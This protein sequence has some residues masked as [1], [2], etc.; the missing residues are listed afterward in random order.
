MIDSP[1]Q[2]SDSSAPMN[3]FPATLPALLCE[4]I[5]RPSV[6][7][8]GDSGGTLANETLM[9][10][11]VAGLLRGLGGEVTVTQVQPGRPNVVARFPC[12]DPDA[13][14]VALVPH[15]DTVG[16]RGMTVEPFTPQLR[17]GRIYGRG[18]SDTKGPMAA[19]LWA[20][21]CWVK[22]DAARSSG[23]SW[24]FAATMGEEEMSTGASALCAAGFRAD[25]AIA[26]EPTDL[27]IIRASKGVLRLWLEASGVACHAST[28]EK[29]V[30]AIYKALPFLQA[31]ERELAP[32][33]A[34]R[35]HPDLGPVSINVGI[36]SGG[37]EW[38]IVPDACRIGLDMRTH[39][40]FANDAV[41]EAVRA[42][43]VAVTPTAGLADGRGEGGLELRVHRNGPPYVLPAD[44][45]WVRALERHARGVGV[46]P[47]FSDA[48]VFNAHGTPAVAFGPGK[49]AQA[50][51]KDEFISVDDL[52]EGAAVLGRF[53]AEVSAGQS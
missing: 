27:Q 40:D 37:G 48:N 18:A 44:N 51:T 50:H 28:P 24:V 41:L 43:A 6:S 15:L 16:V 13:P 10:D 1:A 45:R 52:E 31:C 34:A 32:G 12:A 5:A 11:Y 29:G 49:M 23:V 17:E 3:D 26:L 33:F 53:I 19:A 25:F 4:L 21:A 2:M 42:A 38:N 36:L 35:V 46:A 14:V 47:W 7:P 8:E 20:L 30:N 9:A 39:P 22:S